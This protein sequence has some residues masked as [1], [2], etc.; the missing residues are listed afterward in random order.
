MFNIQKQRKI[1]KCKS[2]NK[3]VILI[4]FFSTLLFLI[5]VDNFASLSDNKV[6][7]KDEERKRKSKL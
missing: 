6:E 1:S 4:Q 3:H 2:K 7:E 5:G